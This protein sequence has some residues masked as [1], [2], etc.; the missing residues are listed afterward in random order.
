MII[1]LSSMTF[2]LFVIDKHGFTFST[3]CTMIVV[4]TA[5][6]SLSLTLKK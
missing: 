1:I 2:V 3:V 5:V 6:S 4:A